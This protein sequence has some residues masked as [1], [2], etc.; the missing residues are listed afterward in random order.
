MLKGR[1]K[2]EDM[3]STDDWDPDRMMDGSYGGGMMDGGGMWMMVLFGVVLLVLAGTAI[4]WAF[5]AAGSRASDN[6]KVVGPVVGPVV[7]T[8]SESP[9]DVLDLR[10]ARGEISPEEYDTTRTLLAR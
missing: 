2:G 3:Y 1:G 4:F 10:L 5:K 7:G 9:R 8:V 6:G